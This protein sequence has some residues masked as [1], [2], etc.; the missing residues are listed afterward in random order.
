M[1]LY[2]N[3]ERERVNIEFVKEEL[4]LLGNKVHMMHLASG[5]ILR[6][7]LKIRP[8]I[9][10]T[11]P[12]TTQNQ[13]YIYTFAKIICGSIIVTFTTEGLIDF[14]N[15]ENLAL[16]AGIYDYSDKLI[17]Y[18]TF[19]G[20][21]VAEKL[22]AV[23]QKQ[24]K[25]SDGERIR[26]FGNPMYEKE[27][28]LEYYGKNELIQKLSGNS[29]KKI[30]VLTGFHAS[31]YEKDEIIN[32]QDIIDINDRDEE[33]IR[34][35][36]DSFK[37]QK[38]YSEKY[39]NCV[40]YAAEKNPDILFLVKLHPQEILMNK[41]Q[42]KLPYLKQL[43]NVNNIMLIKESIPIGVLLSQVDLMVHYGSTVDL[44]AYIYGIPTLK[45]E[46]EAENKILLVEGVR[47]TESTYYEDVRNITSID[48]YVQQLK[49][50]DS[51]FRNNENVEKQLYECMNYRMNQK[52]CPSKEF[53]IFL[54]SINK[55]ERLRLGKKEYVDFY[56]WISKQM[57]LR[58][59]K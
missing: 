9:I 54:N 42:H 17:D 27:R 35:V 29:Q 22:G 32:A 31:C 34:R 55:R 36:L 4:E 47:L 11:F 44:E 46:Y 13:I 24:N 52:Y 41:G 18:H 14:E 15:Q 8:D 20:G 43:E 28:I 40:V 30:L 12:I 48:K 59:K 33:E 37:N 23:L 50:R 1:F 26:V 57:M 39:I 6:K 2:N 45:L 58:G 49:G 10:V 56:Y 16:S 25:I 38:I 5:D 53:A 19:W 3:L 51:L 21:L 7:L